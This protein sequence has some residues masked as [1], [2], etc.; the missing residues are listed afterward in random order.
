MLGTMTTL[1]MHYPVTSMLDALFFILK[2]YRLDSLPRRTEARDSLR[3][4]KNVTTYLLSDVFM[5]FVWVIV[6]LIVKLRRNDS[7]RSAD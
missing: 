6:W 4:A 7:G 3:A 5:R 2:G 1:L